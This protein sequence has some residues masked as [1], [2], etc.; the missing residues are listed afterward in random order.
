MLAHTNNV[1]EL[2]SK[3]QI[4][5]DNRIKEGANILTTDTLKGW[6]IKSRVDRRFH[7]V[8]TAEIFEA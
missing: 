2:V 6:F 3:Q 4:K 8:D 1:F 5:P 7:I